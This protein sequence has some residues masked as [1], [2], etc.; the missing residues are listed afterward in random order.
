MGKGKTAREREFCFK[1]SKSYHL[2]FIL[3]NSPIDRD[4]F[5]IVKAFFFPL[6]HLEID[7]VGP[8]ALLQIFAC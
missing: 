4:I 7:K 1:F 3:E 5:T 8:S 2:Y 6:K